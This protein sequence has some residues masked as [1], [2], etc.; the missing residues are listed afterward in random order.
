MKKMEPNGE[1]CIYSCF[2]IVDETF[3]L[4]FP[5]LAA[6]QPEKLWSVRI[7]DESIKVCAQHQ[8]APSQLARM[9]AHSCLWQDQQSR[10]SLI[11]FVTLQRNISFCFVRT[12]QLLCWQQQRQPCR[13]G[14][15]LQRMITKYAVSFHIPWW[16]WKWDNYLYLYPHPAG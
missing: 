13:I 3:L 12:S 5:S 9:R 15:Q 6:A 7:T 8:M 4:S 2:H 11:G 14:T 16:P 1:N 10:C